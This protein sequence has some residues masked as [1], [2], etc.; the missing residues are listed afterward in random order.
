M[1]TV[2]KFCAVIILLYACGGGSEDSTEQLNPSIEVEAKAT[3]DS[4]VT[5]N[6]KTNIPLPIEVMAMIDL[7]G[8]APDDTYIGYSDRVKLETSPF[9]FDLNFSKKKL[10]IGDYEAIV[11]FYPKWGADNGNEKAKKIKVEVADTAYVKLNTP[12]GTVSER[13]EF[14]RKK[15]WVANNVIVGTAWDKKKFVENLGE[16]EELKVTDSKIIKKYYFK[17]ADKTIIVNTLKKSVVTWK[18]GRAAE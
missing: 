12:H 1:K 17:G 9:S 6:V 13:K 10:P 7:K 15:K 16:Y 5:F 4:I 11:R 2:L 8:Q 3:N 14:F 18:N